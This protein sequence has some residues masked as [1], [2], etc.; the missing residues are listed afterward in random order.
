SGW[1][2]VRPISRLGRL[3]GLEIRP[4]DM[5]S[6]EGREVG[7][8]HV[9]QIAV[10]LLDGAVNDEVLIVE[11]VLAAATA[12]TEEPKVPGRVVTAMSDPSA[13]E[14]GAARH[15]VAGDRGGGSDRDLLDRFAKL[16]ADTLIGI[17]VQDP[18]RL[19]RQRL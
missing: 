2:T 7:R 11:P 9:D 14:D 10:Q 3:S 16:G 18:R 8:Q 12:D 1:Q 5:A 17:D 19:D 13:H 4:P 15:Q 6:A